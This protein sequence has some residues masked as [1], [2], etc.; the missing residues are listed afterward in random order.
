M[1]SRPHNLSS[2]DPGA[3]APT[4]TA[5]RPA[6]S[7]ERNL[8]AW[9]VQ[10]PATLDS[11]VIAARPSAATVRRWQ[12]DAEELLASTGRRADLGET[13]DPSAS[14]AAHRSQD[15]NSRWRVPGIPTWVGYAGRLIT[16]NLTVVSIHLAVLRWI[17]LPIGG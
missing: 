7:K 15:E 11:A 13:A 12:R 5:H 4:F 17:F 16:F 3:L 1:A 14:P 8:P 2:R 10:T 6:T 9:R